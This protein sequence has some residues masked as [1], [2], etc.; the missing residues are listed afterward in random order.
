MPDYVCPLG[1]VSEQHK[2]VLAST[3]GYVKTKRLSKATYVG[4]S[5]AVQNLSAS[6]ASQVA[7]EPGITTRAYHDSGAQSP[8]FD[9]VVVHTAECDC[10]PGAEVGIGN[11]FSSSGAGGSAHYGESPSGEGHY[12]PENVIAWHAPPNQGSIGV[13]ITARAAFTA[14]QWASAAV[15]QVLHRTAARVGDLCH[16]YNLPVVWLSPADLLAGK[17]GITGHVCVSQAWQQSDHTDPGAN[18]PV[19]QFL[20]MVLAAIGQP[21]PHV[22]PAPAPGP[23]PTA[24]K[25]KALQTAI[26]ATADGH[27]GAQTDLFSGRV[28]DIHPASG[29]VAIK[30]LQSQIGIGADGVW[31]PTTNAAVVAVTKKV[32]Q[33][34][35]V[36]ADGVWGPGTQQAWATTRVA[37]YGK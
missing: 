8:P 10:V 27:W 34:L 13:E 11:Y 7:G 17:R 14:A 20:A 1:K 30:A 22:V 23:K 37:N 5:A 25:V 3:S 29:S 36:S 16:R 6:L 19:Q 21:S 4:V 35:S 18:F 12:V 24:L 26:R 32:Q 28:R 33:A 31:G 15:Q 2:K 9:R